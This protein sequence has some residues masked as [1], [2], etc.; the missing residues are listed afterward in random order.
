MTGRRQAGVT[1]IME[2]AYKQNTV[3]RPWRDMD[4]SSPQGES[5]TARSDD[6]AEESRSVLADRISATINSY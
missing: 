2:D 5:S 1:I 3:Y 4:P 6:T